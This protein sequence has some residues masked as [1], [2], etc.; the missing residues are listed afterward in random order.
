MTYTIY[1][2][3]H[4]NLKIEEFISELK[5]HN[6]EVLVDLRS[7]PYSRYVPHFNKDRLQGSLDDEKIEYTYFGN[8]LGGRPPEGIEN[9]VRTQKFIDNISELLTILDGKGKNTALMCSEIDH[10]NCHRKIILNEIEKRGRH[11]AVISRNKKIDSN[12]WF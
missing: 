10:N 1:S 2:I 8:K 4:S 9:F 11:V 3:G 7:H 6:I 5:E 12:T